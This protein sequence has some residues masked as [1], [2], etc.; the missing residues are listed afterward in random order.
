MAS[1]AVEVIIVDGTAIMNM[2]KP[3]AAKVFLPY[4]EAQ[5]RNA[6]RL[7]I[8]WDV[9]LPD[10]LRAETRSKR[11]KGI[12]RRVELSSAIPGK[13]NEFLRIEENKKELFGFL[14]NQTMSIDSDK[15]IISTVESEVLCNHKR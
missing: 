15:E 14:A 7:D 4:I 3:G 5:L 10:S 1:P 6:E 2:L 9:Y 12:R 8:M 13:W 11:G